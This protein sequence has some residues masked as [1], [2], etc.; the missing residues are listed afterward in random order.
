MAKLKV[1]NLLD[2]YKLNQK[3]LSI[4]TGINKNTVSKY[5]SNT[6][7]KIDKVHID[8]LCKY[9]KCTPNDIFEI[10]DT[11]KIKPA[12]IIYYDDKTDTFTY[13]EIT[14]LAEVQSSK[15]QIVI[16]DD[17]DENTIWTNNFNEFLKYAKEKG[18]D[19]TP[20]ENSAKLKQKEFQSYIEAEK[21]NEPLSQ[22]Y[23]TDEPYYTEEFEDPIKSLTKEEREEYTKIVNGY[24]IRF[25]SELETDK[26]VSKFIDKLIEFFTSSF[27]LDTSIKQVLTKYEGHDYFTTNIKV[28]KFYQILYRFFTYYPDDKGFVKTLVNIRYIY[29][30]GGLDKLS[31]EEL[32]DIQR[33]LNHYLKNDLN[34]NTDKNKD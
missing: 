8:M 14:P 29:S 30:N 24:Q 9:F 33:T 23:L 7:E 22:E 27:Q 18:V 34:I 16:R 17:V 28:D 3:D 12:Q 2:K 25:D 21:I 10:D 19:I 31:D 4:S 6:F 1:N 5:C 26:L 20:I 15:K 13:S 32:N 11:V